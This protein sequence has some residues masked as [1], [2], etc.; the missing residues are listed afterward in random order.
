[1]STAVPAAP[2]TDA[3]G[4]DA[5]VARDVDT[6]TTARLLALDAVEAA[7]SGH[8]GTAIALA[9]VAE[10]LFQKHLRH[11]PANPDWAGRDRFVLSC[12][13]ASILL[14][15]QLFLTGYG[16]ELD[17]LRSFRALD[18]LTPGHPEYGHT[19]GVETTTG[20]LGQGLATA[21]G[22]AMAMKHERASYDA[23]AA[24]GTSPFDR[25][26]WVLASDGDIQE[27]ISAEAAALAGHHRLDNLVVIYD[28]NDI[29][30]EGSTTLSSSEDVAARFR[31]H[32]WE[33]DRVELA[34]DGDVDVP[35]LD[36]ALA[37][38]RTGRP[39]LVVLKSQIAWPAPNAVG[40]AASH[41][42]PLGQAEAAA[43]REVLGVT[44]G[45]FEVAD[46]VL[47]ATRTALTRGA[48]QH[49]EW[50]Q[51]F[52]A[53]SAAHPE[54]AA[55]LARAQSGLLPEGLEAA[56][57]TWQP[58]EALATRDASGKII[59]ALAEVMPELWGGSADLAEPNRTA[60]HGGGSF[61]PASPAG[62]NVHWGVRE[63]AMAAAMNGITLVSGQRHF[64]GT[65]LV[66]SD[67]Q[68]P[69]I[70]LASLMGLP[71]TYLWSHD[72]VAL[73]SDGPTHQPIEHLAAL[74]AMPGFSVV[75][76]ADAAETAAAW[77]AILQRR[78]PAGLVLARQPIEVAATPAD[79]VAEGVR[80]G[81]YVVRDAAAPAALIVA[82]GSEVSLALGAAEQLAADGVQVRVVS[83]PSREWFAEQ[84][85]DYRAAVLP[86]EL[87]VRVVVEAATSFGWH[88]V[89]GPH[90]RIL[91]IDGFGLSA[92]AADALAARG[93]TVENVV[94]TVREA[95]EARA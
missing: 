78:G 87:D 13:H 85:A 39:R 95:I 41:G 11:D 47:A 84:D 21:V 94:A 15:T 2:T 10:L 70:R 24:L 66:F 43:M 83:M 80:R 56:L 81:A 73:G 22:M 12:G 75:R 3:A 59:Q 17:D 4:T 9:P 49:A 33:V 52:D 51:R 35:A 55:Q 65:F 89:A 18:S 46:E 79:V 8:P 58:G 30:I 71:V 82:T 64:A 53:W 93:M 40:T 76:P 86:A 44:T 91:S 26:V 68:R 72:S 16:L 14:Y 60:I 63:H 54:A 37:A 29:Q 5:V 36:A 92:P 31:A 27:G 34:A 25:T 48:A 88:D 61:L 45:P 20:P 77:L 67:Y 7:G 90:G 69:A 19:P 1:M 62:R 23:D 42:A 57:P 74:R 32:G 38:P 50:Q 28:D 6:V